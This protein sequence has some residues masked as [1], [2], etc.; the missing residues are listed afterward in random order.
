V[1]SRQVLSGGLGVPGEQIRFG[2]VQRPPAPLRRSRRR[3]QMDETE[4]QGQQGRG[5]DGSDEEATADTPIAAQWL[6]ALIPRL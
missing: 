1:G 4:R 2:P 6:L 3:D 5:G